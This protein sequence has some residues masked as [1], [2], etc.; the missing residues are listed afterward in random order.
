LLPILALPLLGF[1]CKESFTGKREA[2]GIWMSRFEYAA[3]RARGNPETAKQMIRDVF[4]KA[5][6]ARFNMVFFQVRGNA[7]AFYRSSLEPW[8]DMLTGRLG[9]DPGWDPLQFAVMR[10]TGRVW[11][12][13]HGSTHSP[14]VAA[15]PFLP[16]HNRVRFSWPIR[17]GLCATK[18]AF[19]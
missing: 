14:S 7:D 18:T 4:A 9:E 13:T 12:C 10:H 19:R 17:N 2:R 16:T 5:R 6:R 3:E 15:R 1:L 11:S 8:S